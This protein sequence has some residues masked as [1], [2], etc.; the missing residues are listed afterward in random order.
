MKKKQEERAI[1]N[2]IFGNSHVTEIVVMD[3]NY[4]KDGEMDRVIVPLDDLEGSAGKD[5]KNV[6]ATLPKVYSIKSII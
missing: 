5:S 4:T 2:S 6:V 3:A 1:Y